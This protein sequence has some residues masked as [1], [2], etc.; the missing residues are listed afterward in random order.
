RR[1]KTERGLLRGFA[2]AVLEFDP[3]ALVTYN[4]M[5]FDWN[6]MLIRAR[7]HCDCISELKKISRIFGKECPEGNISW[8]SNAYGEQNFKYLDPEGRL[9]ID[10]LTEV[11]RN[12]RLTLY[13]L[14]F[15]SE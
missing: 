3:D 2:K 14:N 10:V 7:E 4:G 11:Q 6:Y 1:F 15:V 8:G 9:N 13:N 12:Y 5:K